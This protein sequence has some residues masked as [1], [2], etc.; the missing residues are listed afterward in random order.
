MY[1]FNNVIVIDHDGLFIYVKAGFAGSFHDVRCLRL[2]ELFM[3]W[4][5]YFR[6]ENRDLVEEYLLGD[7]GYMG[8]DMFI[9]RP[10]DNREADSANP[11]SALI[12]KDMLLF[13]FQ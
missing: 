5:Q 3:N 9:L 4:R 12:T 13:E 2:T 1:C 11:L 7:P 10:V 6:N 8:A